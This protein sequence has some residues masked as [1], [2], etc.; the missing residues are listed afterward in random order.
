VGWAAALAGHFGAE[1]TLLHALSDSLLAHQWLWEEG[2]RASGSVSLGTSSRWVAPTHAWL[3]RLSDDVGQSLES[4][5]IVAV[6]APGP[7]ILER[8]RVSRADLIVM[9]RNGSHAMRAGDMGSATRL[10]LRAAPVP[11]LVVPGTDTLGRR[12]GETGVDRDL[13][14]QCSTQP[15]LAIGLQN[16]VRFTHMKE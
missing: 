5:T 3:R 10:T 14:R 16:R 13:K 6:G 8:A 1:L 9:G 4:R 2:A 11:V 7:V 12:L 15:R